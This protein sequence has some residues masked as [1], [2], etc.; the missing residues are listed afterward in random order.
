V[1][2]SVS[3]TRAETLERNWEC[4]RCDA[5]GVVVLRAEGDS[6]W[7][8][9]WWDRDEAE[10]AAHDDA[11]WAVQRDADRIL[12]MIR[13]PSC[14]HRARGVYFWAVVRNL[15][16]F[17]VGMFMGLTLATLSVLF[18]GLPPLAGIPIILACGVIFCLPERRRWVEA[19]D[20]T[21][22]NLVP[23]DPEKVALVRA[24]KTH[25]AMPKAVARALPSKKLEPLAPVITEAPRQVE[26]ASDA[27]GPR[28][29]RD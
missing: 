16:G 9:V 6:G 12:G 21:V 3:V 11:R 29:L 23:G 27:D 26:R 28:F 17:F 13:C 7:K 14:R 15:P 19:R 4:A 24:R 20:T 18:A 22:R 1:S 25:A 5:H 2:V 8:R 10:A